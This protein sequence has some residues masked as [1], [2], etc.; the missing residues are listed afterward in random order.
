MHQLE[1][2]WPHV[3]IFQNPL[4]GISF[5]F[6]PFSLL[7]SSP[8]WGKCKYFKLTLSMFLNRLFSHPPFECLCMPHVWHGVLLVML[9]DL[10]WVCFPAQNGVCVSDGTQPS[11]FVPCPVLQSPPMHSLFIPSITPPAKQRWWR[12]LGHR[13]PRGLQL[14]LAEMSPISATEEWLQNKVSCPA[15]GCLMNTKSRTRER[16]RR[17]IK[18]GKCSIDLPWNSSQFPSRQIDPLESLL[19]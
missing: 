3:L 16:K 4:Q 11:T 13:T 8:S 5:D 6:I 18:E 17:Q 1:I 12:W 19:P 2:S 14:C 10:S 9:T 7:S 15:W